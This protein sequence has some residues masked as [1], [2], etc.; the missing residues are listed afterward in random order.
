[1]TSWK[2]SRRALLQT[3]A[4]AGAGLLAP[5]SSSPGLAQDAEADP[6][7]LPEGSAGKLTV[8]HRTEYF[9]EAQ[10][11]FRETVTSFAEANGAELDIS[12]T[13]PEAF[14]DFLGKM[15]RRRRFGRAA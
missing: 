13:N 2:I 9:E 6:R 4:L 11:L 1:M 14:G 10:T 8:I 5:G 3:T 12:T 7:P 15:R